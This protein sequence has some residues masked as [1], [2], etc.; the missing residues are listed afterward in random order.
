MRGKNILSTPFVYDVLSKVLDLEDEE[1]YQHDL[2]IENVPQDN[3]DLDPVPI[4]NQ[5]PKWAEK[6]IEV[7]GNV[8]GD[9]DDR[10]RT[11]SQYH[12]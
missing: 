1:Q 9:L 8:D 10:R 4:L 6:I 3:L 11:R 7:D 2:D 5:K 12:N